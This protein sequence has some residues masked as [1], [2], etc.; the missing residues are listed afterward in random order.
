MSSV[1]ERNLSKELNEL[2]QQKTIEIQTFETPEPKCIERS[3]EKPTKII[4]ETPNY[5]KLLK[6]LL[7]I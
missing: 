6:I 7:N 4:K 1:N 2:Q 3:I 5:E